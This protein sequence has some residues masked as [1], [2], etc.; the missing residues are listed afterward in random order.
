MATGNTALLAG[1]AGGTS[2]RLAIVEV[3]GGALEVATTARFESR[4][5]PSLASIVQAFRAAHPRPVARACFGVAG[6]VVGGRV[7]TPNLPWVVDAAAL[8]RELGLDQ[9]D[10][11]N[12]LE[13]NAYGIFAL[14]AADFTVLNA[15][16]PAAGNRAVIS[17]GTGLGE[18]G[19]VWDGRSHRPFAT[20]GGHANWAPTTE[21]EA[22][23]L[24]HLSRKFGGHVSAERVVSG[25]G[26]V[27]V[28]EFMRDTGRGQEPGWL[29]E[30]LASH[31][32]AA[33]IST[34]AMNGKS[35]LCAAALDLF[36]SA[37]AAEAGNLAL[38]LM[39]I[40]GVYL[41][42]GI[43][44]KIIARLKTP[45]FVKAFTAKGRLTSLLEAIQVRV[46]MND[47]AALF[48]AARFAA[49]QAS[50]IPREAPMP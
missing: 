48:G 50:L 45:A 19:I 28:Y 8:A 18:A 29:K 49:L 32:H 43:A 25:P 4:S 20:E 14:S 42:G 13:A 9:V 24:R 40:G 6:P 33:V 5:H 3:G 17:A 21:L 7:E 46:I 22:E 38:K 10:V 31:D 47:Q 23:L 11:I 30:A 2:T 41:G 39:A 15:G 26:L 1:D 35:E 27:N 34:N 36:V 44:P 12:D 37:Y 16:A